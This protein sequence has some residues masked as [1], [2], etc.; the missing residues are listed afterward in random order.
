MIIKLHFCVRVTQIL[1]IPLHEDDSFI[2]AVGPSSDG[3]NTRIG[4]RVLTFQILGGLPEVTVADVSP[5]VSDRKLLRCWAH[6]KHWKPWLRCLKWKHFAR[7]TNHNSADASAHQLYL[8]SNE[9]LLHRSS[10][11]P[12][13]NRNFITPVALMLGRRQSEGLWV[14]PYV[15]EINLRRAALS[16][17]LLK[18]K[19][20]DDVLSRCFRSTVLASILPNAF[21]A[22]VLQTMLVITRIATLCILCCQLFDLEFSTYT[23]S[24]SSTENAACCTNGFPCIKGINRRTGARFFLDSWVN[25]FSWR[26]SVIVFTTEV[27]AFDISSYFAARETFIRA[28]V[29]SKGLVRMQRCQV[30]TMRCLFLFRSSCFCVAAQFYFEGES[31]YAAVRQLPRRFLSHAFFHTLQN[32][33]SLF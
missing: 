33:R 28:G 14:I 16:T 32:P 21:Q 13:N 19:P 17:S 3:D 25:R 5:T 7:L 27:T 1:L 22:N 31:A 6:M 18:G 29:S 24:Y 23:K 11:N 20:R 10:C 30:F 9:W 12:I 26:V 8:L 4:R 15:N 2:I